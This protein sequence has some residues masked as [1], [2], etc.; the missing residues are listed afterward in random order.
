MSVKYVIPP[1]LKGRFAWMGFHPEELGF[2]FIFLFV[3]I[4]RKMYFSGNFFLLLA[5]VLFVLLWRPIRGKN[6]LGY[7]RLLYRFYAKPQ[8]FTLRECDAIENQ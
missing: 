5:A 6:V 7:F 4:M 3:G 2:I 1:R 8:V